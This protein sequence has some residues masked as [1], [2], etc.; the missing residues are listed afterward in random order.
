M[1]VTPDL[2]ARFREAAAA[3]IACLVV[4]APYTLARAVDEMTRE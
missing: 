3:A 2:D 1:K 4:I